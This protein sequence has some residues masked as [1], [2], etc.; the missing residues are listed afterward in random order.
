MHK[1]GPPGRVRHSS[2]ITPT[3]LSQLLAK[4]L[5]SRNPDDLQEANKLIKS[6]VKEVSG[7]RAGGKRWVSA[8]LFI[9]TL[10]CQPWSM[11]VQGPP[12]LS[13]WLQDEARI[14]KVTRRMHTLEEVNNNAKLLHE[15]LL[16]CSREEASEADK[17]LMKV[18]G[19]W[20]STI[21]H[22]A[23][24]Q[25]APASCSVTGRRPSSW[26]GWA[27]GV[28]VVTCAPPRPL[29]HSLGPRARQC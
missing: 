13:T 10:A 5:K 1:M 28:S 21:G 7:G 4:L 23:H 14:Q 9:L 2:L 6:M 8:M 26:L 18:G 24:A 15:M 19:P 20:A 17:E 11:A 27:Q 22:Q 25:P 3:L 12:P 16:H 29:L